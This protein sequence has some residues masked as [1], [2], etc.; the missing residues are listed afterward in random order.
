MPRIPA[1]RLKS[2]VQAVFARIGC[3]PYEAERI[4]HYLV[5]ANLVGHDSH[6]V[7]RVPTYVDWAQRDMVRP[8][9]SLTVILQTEALAIV[10]GNFGFGQVLGEQAM[11][12]GIEL[13]GRHGLAAVA[14]RNSGHLGRIGDWPIL[15]AEAGMASLHFVNTSG[16]GVLVAPFGGIDR[17]LSANPIAAGMPVAGGPPLILDIS[18][19]AI[20]EGKLKVAK[21]RGVTVAEN[22]IV[23]HEGRPTV[24]PRDFYATPPGALL[25]FG[26]HKG[27]GLSIMTEMFAGAITGNGCTNPQNNQR[28]L[29]GMLSIIIDPRRL[30]PE[31]DY[32]AEV[33]RF[34]QYVKT[35]RRVPGCEEILMPGDVEQRTRAQRLADGIEIDDTTWRS[36]CDTAAKLGV[37]VGI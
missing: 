23:D 15:V 6:G 20:A 25:P 18:T 13:A 19:S 2:L 5:E 24:D 17:R 36:I 27:Y 12:L 37:D 10:D 33:E 14:L 4:A 35:S 32:A 22:C 11:R 8:N 31:P 29:N 16:M 21:N 9:Q 34:I 7:I 26:G 28:L 30:P 3:E 1:E